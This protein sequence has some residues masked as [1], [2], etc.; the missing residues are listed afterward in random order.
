MGVHEPH[1]RSVSFGD[2]GDQILNVAEGSTDHDAGLARTEPGFY[3]PLPRLIFHE[4][5]IQVQ[6]LEIPT[7]LA[8][9]ILGLDQLG[10]QYYLHIVRDVHGL[11]GQYGLQF[12][13]LFFVIKSNHAFFFF[14]FFFFFFLFCFNF[15]FSSLFSFMGAMMI[16]VEA[17]RDLFPY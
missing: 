10:L 13:F 5:E 14:F 2:T 12:L 15:S 9:R 4:L 8:S 1:F 6:M 7:K 3:L 16:Y 11:G 17:F